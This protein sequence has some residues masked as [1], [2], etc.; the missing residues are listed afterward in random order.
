MMVFIFNGKILNRIGLIDSTSN[1]RSVQFLVS[2]PGYILIPDDPNRLL[3]HF[4]MTTLLSEFRLATE[5]F[6]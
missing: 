3:H 2:H 4:V 6:N 1:Q 5:L